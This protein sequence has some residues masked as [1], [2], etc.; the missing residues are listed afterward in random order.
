MVLLPCAPNAGN[1]VFPPRK[2]CFSNKI[3]KFSIAIFPSPAEA[4]TPRRPLFPRLAPE[5]QPCPQGRSA[6]DFESAV[7]ATGLMRFPA[8]AAQF[9]RFS[10]VMCSVLAPIQTLLSHCGSEVCCSGCSLPRR[11]FAVCSCRNFAFLLLQ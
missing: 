6:A 2:C 9:W 7:C 3:L 10:R 8:N 1:S 11:F 4:L 5:R